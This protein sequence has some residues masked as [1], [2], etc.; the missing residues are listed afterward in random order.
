MKVQ[1]LDYLGIF[2]PVVFWYIGNIS[3]CRVPE[4]SAGNHMFRTN[5]FGAL[6]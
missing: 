5:V 3:R 1:F 4:H 2:V 6:N